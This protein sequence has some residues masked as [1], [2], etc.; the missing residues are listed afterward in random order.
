MAGQSELGSFVNL[1][2]NDLPDEI[3]MIIFSNVPAKD[4]VQ[5]CC[6][7]NK[8]WYKVV[9][10]QTLW[11]IKCQKERKY[12]PAVM[13]VS[14]DFKKLYFFNPYARN[15]I[16]NPC[17]TEGM[18]HW[19]VTQKGGDQFVVEATPSGSVPLS[20]IVDASSNV[21]GSIK[22]WATSYSLCEKYQ[23]VDLLAEGCTE[24]VLDT[25]QPPIEVSEWYAGRFDCGCVYHLTVKLLSA[26]KKVIKTFE[27]EERV[28]QWAGK[29]WEQVMHTFKDYGTGVRYVQFT[30]SGKD[31]QFW[32]G[33]YGPKFTLS[34]VRFNF[35]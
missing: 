35:T 19:K 1:S 8:S 6:L 18:L 34:S 14:D 12:V 4:L 31:T 22:N 9:E 17:A 33:H 13:P 28:D 27:T 25:W 15:L 10:Q 24:V 2:L 3:L 32:A 11:R 29:Q 5:C 23:L 21:I 26:T 16:K 7:V 20:T 30:H